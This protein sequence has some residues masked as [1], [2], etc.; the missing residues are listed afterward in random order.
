M[1]TIELKDEYDANALCD[2]FKQSKESEKVEIRCEENQV[3][4]SFKKK[5]P[6]VSLVSTVLT[7]YV[8]ASKEEEMLLEF[9]RTRFYFQDRDEQEQILAITKSIIQGEKPDLPGLRKVSSR[10]QVLFEAFCGFLVDGA[11]FHYESF[12]RFRLKTYQECLQHYVEMAIDE[13]K[14]EQDYQ[15]FIENLRRLLKRQESIIDTVH[16]VFNR[17][18]AL[19]D[20]QHERIDEQEVHDQLDPVLKRGW[21]MDIEPSVLLTLIGMAPKTI[22]LYTD[23]VDAGMIQTIQNVFQERLILCPARA[24]DFHS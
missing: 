20:R 10:K 17:E 13:Y 14:L 15:D 9:I 11:S 3:L 6:G 16:L 1:I 4:V 8:I 5:V 22:F 7:E 12:S 2:R 18:F 21:G 19:Y 24:C 23:N